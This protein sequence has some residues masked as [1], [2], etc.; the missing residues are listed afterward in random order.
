MNLFVL[1]G[2]YRKLYE[3]VFQRS[4]NCPE[5][6]WG[7]AAEDLV[8]MRRWDKVVDDSKSPFTKW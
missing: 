5:E 2:A 7:E 1:T 6:F 8:W 4:I 3:A